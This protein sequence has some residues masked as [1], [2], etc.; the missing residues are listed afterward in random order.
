MNLASV[1]SMT[2]MF[3]PTIMHVAVS[4]ANSGLNL[5]PSLVK[6]STDLLRFLTD[7][8]TKICVAMASP[9]GNQLRIVRSSL[10]SIAGLPFL[11]T[12]TQASSFGIVLVAV[13]VAP[14][15]GGIGQTRLVAALRREIEV[16]VHGA[17]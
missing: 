5:K 6:N 9:F 2:N 1:K 14:P 17:Q 13:V 8:F 11:R 12:A 10:S 15:R 3:S 16:H 7:K 4:S